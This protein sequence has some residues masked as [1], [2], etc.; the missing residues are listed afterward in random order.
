[1]KA[2]RIR[3]VGWLLIILGIIIVCMIPRAQRLLEEKIVYKDDGGFS[4]AI[5]KPL[6]PLQ[7]LTHDGVLTITDGS[8]LY[9]FKRDGTFGSEPYECWGRTFGGTWTASNEFN[10]KDVFEAV[11]T[12]DHDRLKIILESDPGTVTK[13]NTDGYTA[14][15]FATRFKDEKAV[16]LLVAHGADVRV[17]TRLDGLSPLDF[18]VDTGMD[19]LID[20]F[21][22]NGAD[23]NE[24]SPASEWTPLHLAALEGSSDAV[25][26][27]LK[28]GANPNRQ[29]TAG[30]TPLHFAAKREFADHAKLLLEGGADPNLQDREGKTPLDRME[31][32]C[33]YFRTIFQKY[34]A[35]FG[36]DLPLKSVPEV[37]A[38][39]P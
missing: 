33:R 14:L 13:T 8:S 7:L 19:S 25:R 10:R 36:K 22:D 4:F 11:R 6:E 27:L 31:E 38:S 24:V 18:A 15:H 12:H 3:R 21:V 35:K 1:M 23:V 9:C 20:L 28:R 37:K 2:P 5:P 26:K 30:Q 32:K 39:N 16:K 34:G 29:D 17:R